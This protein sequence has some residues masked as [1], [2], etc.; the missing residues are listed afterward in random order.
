MRQLTTGP[1]YV[2]VVI[3]N[4]NY[5]NYIAEAMES[6]IAQTYPHW[7]MIVVDDGSVDNSRLEIARLVQRH[8]DR[9]TAVLQ[10]N[11]GQA[12]AFN[13]GFR[14]AKGDI[15]CFLDSDDYWY[16]SKLARIVG[17][18]AH[19]GF[20]QHNLEKDGRPYRSFDHRDDHLERMVMDGA[21]DFFVP[22]SG[23]SFRR[24]VLESIFPLPENKL[25]I[26]A[27]AFITRMALHYAR[28]KSVDDVLGFYRVHGA[29]GFC[30][31]L[32]KS[33]PQRIFRILDMVNSRLRA[34]G[35]PVIPYKESFPRARRGRAGSR[36]RM[37]PLVSIITPSFNHAAYIEKTIECVSLQ[38]YRNIEHIVVDGDSSDGTVEI[39]ERW[40]PRIRYI[41][42]RDR[43]QSNAI[44]KGFRMASGDVVAWL[45]SDDRY[46]SPDVISNVVDFFKRNPDVEMVYGAGDF[47]DVSGT[48]LRKAYIHE[49]SQNHRLDFAW[50][51]GILQPAVFFR[52]SV[53]EKVGYLDE[54]NHSCM[55]YEYWVRLA[56]A[57]VKMRYFDKT[58]AQA[59][60]HEDMKSVHLRGR[61]IRDIVNIVYRY[62]G[63]VHPRWLNVYA[64]YLVTKNVQIINPQSPADHLPQVERQIQSL[65]RELFRVYNS[66]PDAIRSLLDPTVCDQSVARKALDGFMPNWKSIVAPSSQ[67]RSA[68][69]SASRTSEGR[70]AR[71]EGS[72]DVVLHPP[73]ENDTD[74]SDQIYRLAWYVPEES[75]ISVRVLTSGPRRLL[76]PADYM[77]T[78]RHVIPANVEVVTL[79]GGGQPVLDA[80][81]R[82]ARMIGLWNKNSQPEINEDLAKHKLRAL[83]L[84]KHDHSRREPFEYA[85]L[86]HDLESY[87]IRQERLGDAA[88]RLEELA[89]KHTFRKAYVFG[90][91]PSLEDARKFDFSD[92]LRIVSNSI[93]RNHELLRHIKPHIIVAA[94]PLFHFGCSMYAAVFRRELIDTLY[95]YD[96]AFAYP[97]F[98]SGLFE[99]HYPHLNGRGIPIP[100][101]RRDDFNLDLRQRFMLRG[102]DN[103]LTLMLLPIASTLCDEIYIL[104][105]DGRKPEET[106]FWQHHTASQYGDLMDGV[107]KCHPGFF[108]HIVYED[109]YDQHCGNVEQLLCQG[110]QMGRRYYSI[111][112]TYIPALLKRQ[113]TDTAKT[114]KRDLNWSA[115]SQQAAIAED[116]AV[117]RRQ[118][119]RV[120]RVASLRSQLQ[121]QQRAL[122]SLTSQRKAVQQ[123]WEEREGEYKIETVRLEAEQDKANI[124]HLKTLDGLRAQ[125]RSK[126]KEA[127]EQESPQLQ[128]ERRRMEIDDHEAVQKLHV[129]AA[130]SVA[131]VQGTISI[132]HDEMRGHD[133][134]AQVML[135]QIQANVT[136]L[137]S[138]AERQ[139]YEQLIHRIT[140]AVDA[141]LPRDATVLVISKGDDRLLKLSER[142]AW[143]FPRADNG[144]YAGYYP[145]D[146]AAA[147]KHLEALRGKGASFLVVPATALWWFDHYATFKRHLNRYR[148]IL[149]HDSCVIYELSNVAANDNERPVPKRRVV[150]GGRMARSAG[151]L[152]KR[153]SA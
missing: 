83:M 15:V 117:G 107:K 138:H 44:N 95:R 20:V 55:D 62:Y 120:H 35:K 89:S 87:S 125:I 49:T 24:E 36:A 22:T 136:T 54:D 50:A 97:F 118:D 4:Y 137:L 77:T 86:A 128:A 126:N 78:M 16:P 17:E 104:G 100:Q 8:P 151:K 58:L 114:A 82:K 85:K 92:G 152:R 139:Q 39:L 59:L 48:I 19:Y 18:H 142:K 32:Q 37:K 29:N 122:E 10:A 121:T 102:I 12:A 46:A 143:H 41:S 42:E 129:P 81:F 105:C 43:G 108:D 13:E 96:A 79:S 113:K 3:P 115:T 80:Q 131:D 25:R 153:S 74:F 72:C 144:R 147:I 2:S 91:G 66:S 103:V 9:I 76:P 60:Y 7:E 31:S 26:C 90:T 30:N 61:Q 27:D 53:F 68:A 148:R 133:R 88:Q 149:T 123:R 28:L 21:F 52:N 34:L 56:H 112:T 5:G 110:E 73:F 98:Y 11:F 93:V 84:D 14:R 65:E 116:A 99:C 6:V 75:G 71:L 106:Y 119:G 1:S 69:D 33:D 134:E 130:V 132:L 23:L 70:L 64:K 109:Y 67:S 94:D 124:D 111:T 140:E 150:G 101:E 127:Q 38:D 40:T 51:V 135:R 146:S 63:F 145:A 45:N 57:G 47:V 141:S